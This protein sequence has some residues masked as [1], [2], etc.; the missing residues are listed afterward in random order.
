MSFLTPALIRRASDLPF[1]PGFL[2]M[3]FQLL[4][5]D[6]RAGLWIVRVRLQ[7]GARLER[8]RHT[9]EV[10]AFTLT[11]AWHYLEHDGVC[12]PG[13]YLYEPAGSLHQLE[14]LPANTGTT[15]I[16]FVVR[17]TNEHLDDEGRITKRRDAAEILTTYR[18]ACLALDIPEPNVI[19]G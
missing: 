17:G 15:E 11:G 6:I 19:G 12:E 13:A 2:G 10:F 4:Q 18:S 16:C 9:G 5:V 8:H 7:P 3:E 14:A 1:V